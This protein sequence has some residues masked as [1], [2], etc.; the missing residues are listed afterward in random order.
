MCPNVDQTF[1]L[2]LQ[3]ELGIASRAV[4]LDISEI[5]NAEV[6]H[7]LQL[8]VAAVHQKLIGWKGSAIVDQFPEHKSG[9]QSD[10]AYREWEEDDEDLNGYNDSD[11]QEKEDDGGV[12]VSMKIV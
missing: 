1:P 5:G 12:E 10:I 2:D 7:E 8:F 11:G 9:R 3:G 4:R 6:R